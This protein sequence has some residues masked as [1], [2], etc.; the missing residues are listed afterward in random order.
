[1]AGR[2]G[3]VGAESEVV[4]SARD[5]KRIRLNGATVSSAEELRSRVHTLVFTPGP[6]GGGEG[7]ACAPAART[8]TVSLVRAL[9]ARADL[10]TGLRSRART[11][12]RGAPS[13]RGAALGS[14]L[15]SS[16]GRPRSPLSPGS[17]G[18]AG[19]R[20]FAPVPDVRRNERP[21]SV[22]SR[23]HSGTPSPRRA[24]LSTSGSPAT[25]SAGRR[26]PRSSIST[27]FGSQE[28]DLRTFGSQGEQRIAVLALL[29]AEAEL[30][31]AQGA[32]APLLL[33]DDALSEL[34]ADR[35][36]GCSAHGSGSRARPW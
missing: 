13:C 32:V 30:L 24:R 17:S 7:W 18:C 26:A 28:I 23:Q 10:P 1:M 12:K 36:R 35:R 33:L 6:A 22:S 3:D 11:A 8:S 4:F 29:L 25:S 31:A 15:P 2:K 19:T 5:S 34:D 27:R 16:R 9:P 14:G 21:S 20:A